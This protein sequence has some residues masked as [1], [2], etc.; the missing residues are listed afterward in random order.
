VR[1]ELKSLSQKGF[2]ECFQHLNSCWHK[3]IVAQ[4]DCFEGNVVKMIVIFCIL[5]EIK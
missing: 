4:E 3:C 5:S 1:E 2:Q